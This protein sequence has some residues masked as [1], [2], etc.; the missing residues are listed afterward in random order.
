MRLLKVLGPVAAAFAT[1]LLLSV[2]SQPSH[3]LSFSFQ[4]YTSEWKDYAVFRITNHDSCDISFPGQCTVIASESQFRSDM[5]SLS[6]VR[7]RRG[8]SIT[9]TVHVG[10]HRGNWKITMMIERHTFKSWLAHK[11]LA[12][13]YLCVSRV[14]IRLLDP[15]PYSGSDW[16]T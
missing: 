16:I 5:R 6:G 11:L 10:R 12:C 4:C 3:P 1:I 13:D 14:G 15:P 7:L 9:A 2:F 8:A